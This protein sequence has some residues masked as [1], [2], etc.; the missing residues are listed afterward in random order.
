MR[1]KITLLLLFLNVALFFFIFAFEQ[2]W[3]TEE[4]AAEA[5]TRV[6]GPEAANI[7]GLTISGA[8]LEAPIQLNRRGEEWTI[9]SPYEWP[10]NP[11]AVSRIVNELQFLEH[12]TSFSVENLDATGLSLAD[13]G[14]ET[15]NLTVALTSGSVA[16]PAT[17][18]LAIGNR[19]EIGQ[20]LYVLSPEGDR[21][22]VVPDT[23][24]QSLSL[25]L[26]QLRA[27]S[28][29][30]IPV[31]E[32]RSLN[33]Q[34]D[35]PANVRVRLRN[36]NN[37]W[38]FESPVVARASKTDTDVV[39]NTI[40]T[41]RTTDFLGAPSR[42]P[43]LITTAGIDSPF[44]RITLEG[45]NRRETLLL[46]DEIN[47]DTTPLP[48][49]GA[50]NPEMANREF[51]AQMEGRDAIFTV[52]IPE[53][54][55]TS[56]RNAQSE[57][58]D[59]SVLDLTNRTVD[60]ITL[61]DDDGREVVLQKVETTNSQAAEAIST[62]QV[63]QREADGTLRTQPAD[64]GIIENDLLAALSGLR[65][66]NF[67]RDVPTDAEL[68]TWGL[69]RPT[70]TATLSFETPLGEENAPP[71]LTLNLGTDQAGTNVFAQVPPETFV[72][73]VDPVILDQIPVDPLRYRER[74]LRELP[75]GV[76]IRG[77]SLHDL[78]N[79]RK[80]WESYYAE[81][82]SLDKAI[83][84]LPPQQ[85][86]PLRSLRDEIRTLRAQRLVADSFTTTVEVT[87]QSQPWRFRLDV[88]LLVSGDE[89]A[90]SQQFS[91]Y[92]ADRDGGDRQL[93]GSPDLDVVFAASPALVDALWEIS[94]AERDPG[95]TE[96]TEPPVDPAADAVT[97]PSP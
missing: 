60:S 22:H 73:R 57:L 11:H 33:L 49:A 97:E 82:D 61:T 4:L 44:L 13:Y 15:P 54:L 56:L 29:F 93:V 72:Y 76:I 59:R 8:S 66:T 43:E 86:H 96:F 27:N 17:T 37:R 65:A 26:E 51:Y 84:I 77:F 5:R 10:A 83:E 42:Q 14:L 1:T 48:A 52:V 75:S 35:G 18:T 58:R 16:S 30:T 85:A 46:G 67:E 50:A 80:L 68:E 3:R 12:E 2:N 78:V 87:G 9:T 20:R 74:L 88:E 7:Q 36:E 38:R 21:V 40:A 70:R 91:L 23:L 92:F 95:P 28:C 25:D 41:L 24:A 19:T 32:V 6:L 53:R 69:T 81:A 63:V 71:D 45:N 64:V 94:Y 55:A 47:A 34:N 79:D 89:G 90:Q 62:W 31:F 39:V